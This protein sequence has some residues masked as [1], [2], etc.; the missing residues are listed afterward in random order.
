[1]AAVC[2]APALAEA[3]FGQL[4]QIAQSTTVQHFARIADENAELRQKKAN[5][6]NAYRTNLE[7]LSSLQQE[8]KNGVEKVSSQTAELERLTTEK[9]EIEAAL[10]AKNKAAADTEKQLQAKDSEIATL[11]TKLKQEETNRTQLGKQKAE[12]EKNLNKARE[13]K[14][15]I[16]QELAQVRTDLSEKSEK[17]SRLEKLEI[18]LHKK[19]NLD[20]LCVLFYPVILKCPLIL[21]LIKSCIAAGHFRFARQAGPNPHWRPWSA[22]SFDPD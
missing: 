4:Q 10:S 2:D 20:N 9:K 21:T 7:S 13:D 1:M 11:K 16:E 8:V 14:G 6:E 18:K 15:K 3:F 5:L 22:C 19:P 17:L 12:G